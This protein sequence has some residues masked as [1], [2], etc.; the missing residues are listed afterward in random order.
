MR[1]FNRF[2]FVTAVLML[3]PFMAKALPFVPTTSPESSS[4]HWYH[5]KTLNKFV[6]ACDDN[7]ANIDLDTYAGISDDYLWCFVGTEATGYKIYNL[8]MKAYLEGLSFGNGS[9]SNTSYYEAGS[10]DQFYI[11]L[12]LMNQKNYLCYSAENG[13]YGEQNKLNSYTV[14][15]ADIVPPIVSPYYSLTPYDYQIPNNLLSNTGGEGYAKLIDGDK[16]SRWAVINNSGKWDNIWFDFMSDVAFTPTAYVMTTSSEIYEHPNRNPRAWKIYAKADINDNWDVIANE[17][18]GAG[19]GTNNRSAYRFALNN[20][21]KEYKYF[22][23]E[24]SAI[25]GTENGYYYFQ[26]A[27]LQFTGKT[28]V[29]GDV[30][31][32]GTVDVDDLNALI[33]MMLGAAPQTASGDVTG[34]NSVDIDDVNAVINIMLGLAPGGDENTFTVR[35]V[36]FKMVPVEGGT[37]TM[38]ATAEQGSDAQSNEYPTHQVTLSD[39]SIGE[40]EVTQAL[41]KAVMGSNPSY[42]Q[43]NVNNPAE[44]VSYDDC[45]SFISK[46]NE[47]T[48]KSFRLP[49]EAEWEYAARGGNKSKGYK[50]A[51]E[52]NLGLVGW[53]NENS[54]YSTHP[55]GNLMA[56]E[57]GLYDM[58]GN[59]GEYCADGMNPYSSDAQT[60]PLLGIN[61]NLRVYRGGVCTSGSSFC[62]VSSRAGRSR[63]SGASQLGLRLALTK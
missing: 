14:T 22:R 36:T 38:G 43:S 13:F 55:V 3:L 20:I 34:D 42:N 8:G 59:V 50:Y 25:N 63:S 30:T 39:F 7:Y 5:L 49:T 46:L 40:T 52:N 57:L 23:F 24:V 27:E 21:T 54:G 26:L 2:A 33:N 29:T 44:N 6:Y 9:G 31:G 35:G 18:N 58:S 61:D 56:N 16:Y 37:F 17:T 45:M 10:G 51:G 48:G 53:Y 11:Y 60:N 1:V 12:F 28:H 41:W 4:T 15:E 19:L 47:L 62:R 32:D